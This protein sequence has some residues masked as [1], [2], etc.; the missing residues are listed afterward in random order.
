[1]ESNSSLLLCSRGQASGHVKR[2][3]A[4]SIHTDASIELNGRLCWSAFG[5]I[6][7]ALEPTIYTH[8][9][10]FRILVA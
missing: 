3:Q 6:F 9:R 2:Y 4:R 7:N 1:M 5:I 10:G 8:E